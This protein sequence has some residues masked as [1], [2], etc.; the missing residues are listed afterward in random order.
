MKAAC[1]L[2]LEMNETPF[3]VIFWINETKTIQQLEHLGVV[4]Y[5][6]LHV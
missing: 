3:K 2:L 4:S 6:G 5:I 1:G